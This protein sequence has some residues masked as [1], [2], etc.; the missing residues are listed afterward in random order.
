MSGVYTRLPLFW[1]PGM[2]TGAWSTGRRYSPGVH[3]L[4]P[5]HSKGI[6]L[7]NLLPGVNPNRQ[8]GKQKQAHRKTCQKTKVKKLGP[9]T[10]LYPKVPHAQTGQLFG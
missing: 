2:L 10:L 5:F 7:K 9:E 1:F 3:L 8:V 6:Q 4:V